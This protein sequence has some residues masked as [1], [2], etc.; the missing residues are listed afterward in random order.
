MRHVAARERS[1]ELALTGRMASELE[2]A[3]LAMTAP[4][5]WSRR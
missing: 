1:L 5:R 3:A 4:D 2:H